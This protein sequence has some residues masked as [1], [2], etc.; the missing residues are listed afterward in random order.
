MMPL[1]ARTLYMVVISHRGFWRARRQM[2]SPEAFVRS[3]KLG[4]GTE[5][6]VRD[7]DGR[8]V[9]SHD[10]ARAG[11]LS[12]R[13]FIGL[14]LRYG[15]G[16]PLALNVKADGLQE[17]LK[18][19]LRKYGIRNYF[20]F[21][22]SVPDMRHYL[23]HKLRVFTRQSEYE[24]EPALYA[25]ARGVWLDEFE[26]HWITEREMRRHR[27]AGK[28]V[29]IVS[30]ELHGRSHLRE[31]KHYRAMERRTGIRDV[32]LCTDYPGEARAFFAEGAS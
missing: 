26:S 3:F 17:L 4:F 30:P 22:M 20:F 6:D 8:L 29:C 15:R 11:C 1:A 5:T 19:A 27:R 10:V 32:L 14:Y 9:I 21:D 16:L 23:R 18:A 7:L 28:R 12:F 24:R 31:W 2:N 25:A 13:D